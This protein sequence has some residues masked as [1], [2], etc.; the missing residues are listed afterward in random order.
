MA[1]KK[2]NTNIIDTINNFANNVYTL[3][4]YTINTS[5]STA[6]ISSGINVNDYTYVYIPNNDVEYWPTSHW[7]TSYSSYDWSTNPFEKKK[8]TVFLQEELDI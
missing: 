3:D 4:S 1:K 2:K 8:K 7:P 6:S 5:S